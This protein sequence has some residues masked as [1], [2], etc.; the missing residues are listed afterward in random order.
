CWKYVDNS[1]IVRGPF[2]N[3]EMEKWH[4]QGYIKSLLFVN[5]DKDSSGHFYRLHDRFPSEA[6]IKIQ[7]NKQ[8]EKEGLKISEENSQQQEDISVG[9]P[10]TDLPISED[11]GDV[12]NKGRTT[13][14]GAVQPQVIQQQIQHFQL[15]QQQLNVIQ[16]QLKQKSDTLQNLEQSRKVIQPQ[17]ESFEVKLSQISKKLLEEPLPPDV[18]QKWVD[19]YYNLRIQE[20]SKQNKQLTEDIKKDAN[21]FALDN[22]QKVLQDHRIKQF[23][24]QHATEITAAQNLSQQ[25]QQIQVAYTKEYND[26]QLLKQQFVQVQQQLLQQQ[27]LVQQL[28][29]QVQME[30]QNIPNVILQQQQAQAKAQQ[31]GQQIPVSLPAPIPVPKSGSNPTSNQQGQNIGVGNQQQINQLSPQLLQ[32]RN[33]LVQQ[34]SQQQSQ[35]LTPQQIAQLPPSQHLQYPQRLQQGGQQYPQQQQQQQIP[36]QTLN[37][38]GQQKVQTQNA[39]QQQLF[40][41]DPVVKQ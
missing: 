29:Q 37:Q 32:Q 1:G 12:I 28:Q 39:Q 3:K 18:L 17:K 40:W 26:Y 2:S 4:Q 11:F 34:P 22:A 10:F 9:H 35:Q 5:L 19:Y 33:Q 7:L 13:S 8:I 24:T 27:Q 41:G 36:Q 16:V 21:K 23:N 14:T 6:R 15:L 20:I 30:P 25:F 38:Q 31:R